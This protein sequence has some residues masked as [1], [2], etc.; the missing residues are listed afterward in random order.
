[1]TWQEAVVHQKAELWEVNV[2]QKFAG[3]LSPGLQAVHQR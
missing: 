3:V 1:M 2:L